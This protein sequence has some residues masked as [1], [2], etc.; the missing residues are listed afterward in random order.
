MRRVAAL[1]L[2]LTCAAAQVRRVTPEDIPPELRALDLAAT[3]E[4]TQRRVAEGERDHMIFH[5]LQSRRFTELPR[6]EPALS[7]R[8]FAESNEIPR[9]A[10][11]RLK[12]FIDTEPSDARHRYFRT[13]VS[14]EEQMRGEYRRAMR[15]LHEKEWASRSRQGSDRRD[16]I[17]GLYE[18]RG[19]STDSSA[20]ANYAAHVAIA[21]LR[22]RVPGTKIRRV[23]IV[24]PG[25]EIA[26][27][28]GLDDEV[29]PQSLQPY[30][31]ADSL[32]RLELAQLDDLKI[33]CADVNR[34]VVNHIRE[35]PRSD[36]RLLIKAAPGDTE[37][38]AFFDGAGTA[39]GK[40]QSGNWVEL[41]KEA[42]TRVRAFEMNVLTERA[43]PPA[44]YDLVVAT[45]VLLYFNQQE[46]GLTLANIG[47]SLAPGGHLLHNDTR[48]AVE[49][50]A[51]VLGLPIID[52]RMVRLASRPERELYDSAILHAKQ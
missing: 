46:L 43:D 24:G 15:F 40:R 36:R 16:F 2:A 30:L 17:A 20:A 52:A 25:M 42:A 28:T 10:A 34:R 35:F 9:G 32:I 6:I 27:R 33:D 14:S 23:L 19:H 18:S 44:A 48:A 29:P 1:A 7:A 22:E 49:A 41:S 8:A 3:H 21:A 13:L 37:W 31:T 50:W 11:A 45:N 4:T 26:P 39:I 47:A 38:N 51:R 5:A 12:A